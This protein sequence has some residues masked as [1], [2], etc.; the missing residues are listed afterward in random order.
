MK[1]TIPLPPRTKKNSQRK[2]KSGH[3]IP[4][5]AYEQYEKD[6][7]WFMPK[8][9]PINYKVNLKAVFYIDA[10]R[11]SDLVGYLQAIQDILVKYG[12]LED[13]NRKIVHSTDGSYVEVDRENPRVEIEI[14]E[15]KKDG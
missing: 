3:I 13:D 14:L 1:F 15:V 4:S 5:A 6:C 11:K 10:D 12:V 7:G 8:C 9:K 2:T